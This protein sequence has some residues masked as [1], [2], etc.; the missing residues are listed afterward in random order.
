MFFII[1]FF[2]KYSGGGR[3]AISFFFW[4]RTFL[5]GP[6]PLVRG[7]GPGGKVCANLVGFVII[8]YLLSVGL[9]CQSL[10]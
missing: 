8:K 9:I 5:I 6:G 10:W 4:T 7:L 2:L 1:L 3:K